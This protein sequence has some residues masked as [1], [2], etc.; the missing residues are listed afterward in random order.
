MFTDEFI[1]EPSTSS[2][3]V[4]LSEKLSSESIKQDEKIKKKKNSRINYIKWTETEISAI[5]RTMSKFIALHKIPQQHDR[6]LAIQQE[7]VLQNRNWKKIKFQVV[8]LI[9]KSFK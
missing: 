4:T 3:A 8:N 5:K 6:L 7:P 2:Q 9:K 1:D